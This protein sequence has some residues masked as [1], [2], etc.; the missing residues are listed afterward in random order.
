MSTSSKKLKSATALVPV[1]QRAQFGLPASASGLEKYAS[2]SGSYLGD[3]LKVSGRDGTISFGAQATE[4]KPGGKFAALLGEA[5]VGFIEWEEGTPV[6]QAWMRLA[7]LT[8]ERDL[9]ALRTSLGNTDPAD[10]EEQELNGKPKDPFRESVML[11][12]VELRS[13]RLFTFSSSSSGGVRAVKR[14]VKNA[15]IHLRAV[16]E[17]ERNHV[18]VIELGVGSYTSR[19]KQVGQIFFP[20]FEVEDWMSPE[21]VL[22][23]LG[24]SGNASAFGAPNTEALNADLDE[25]AL[26]RTDDEPDESKA[27][28]ED[29]DDDRD[30]Q[31]RRRSRPKAEPVTLATRKPRNRRFA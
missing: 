2:D 4:M 31:P 7:D 3:L 18:P 5:K 21:E 12:L 8:D 15:L 11:P 24:R 29:D 30:E 9:R 23:L 17:A 27:T 13:G 1:G 26:D 19:N 28:S 20:V 22:H 25:P 6:D 10:W 14:L 16:P